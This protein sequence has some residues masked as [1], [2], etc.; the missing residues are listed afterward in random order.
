MNSFHGR[1]QFLRGAL[2]MGALL[3][4][5]RVL[6]AAELGGTFEVGRWST[7]EDPAQVAQILAGNAKVARGLR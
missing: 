1:R 4:A 5:G 2:A 6:G 3:G 7:D